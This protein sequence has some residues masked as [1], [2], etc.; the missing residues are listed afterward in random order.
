LIVVASKQ[1]KRLKVQHPNFSFILN[2]EKVYIYTKT[3]LSIIPKKYVTMIM[4]AMCIMMVQQQHIT[5]GFVATTTTKVTTMVV[6]RG[7]ELKQLQHFV[8]ISFSNNFLF[9]LFHT[10]THIHS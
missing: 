7:T 3:M 10:Y 6:R 2:N 5:E 1:I 4:I 9:H 8:Q